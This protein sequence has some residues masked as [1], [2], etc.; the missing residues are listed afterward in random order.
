MSSKPRRFSPGKIIAIAVTAF[1]LVVVGTITIWRLSVSRQ[2]RALLK[3]IAARGEPTNSWA[4]NQSYAAVPDAENAASVWLN[5][6]GQLT[7]GASAHRTWQKFKLP[8]RGTSLNVTNLEF[9][10]GIV[11]SNDTALATFRE[12]AALS[13]SRYPIDLTRGANTLLPHLAPL[14][15]VARLL[16]AEAL[17]AVEDRD[18]RRATEAIRAMLAA[19]RSLS[20]E[21][22]LIS[23]LASCAIDAIA[24]ETAGIVI[25]QLQL[26][27][28]ELQGLAAVFARSDDTNRLALALVGERA[29]LL[30]TLRDP[31][32]FLSASAGGPP[33]SQTMA[34]SFQ[35]AVWPVI[36]A[37]GFFERDFGFGMQAMTTNIGLSRLPDPQ[38][39]VARTNWDLVEARAREGHYVL[40]SLLL[41]GFSKAISRDTDARARARVAQIVFAIERYRLP[42][43]GELPETLSAL[44][45]QFLPAVLRDPF[46]GQP[47]R[48]KRLESGY[49]VYSIGPDAVDD[50]GKERPPKPKEKETW[51]TTFI[52]ERK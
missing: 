22:I 27:D 5:G 28:V 8:A 34:D 52:V 20:S 49:M 24:F 30:T 33:S 2:N 15:S 3:A 6:I 23:Q 26:N 39:F 46:D 7:A 37:T 32:V 51:D 50:S 47:L 19:S 4:L 21:P 18:S 11:G 40:S 38:R 14:K 43:N 29:M 42:H 36:R 44:T 31:Q 45:P 13:K 41:P 48:F 1:V 9:A 25:N 35:D 17:V 16:Q 10:R 12:A